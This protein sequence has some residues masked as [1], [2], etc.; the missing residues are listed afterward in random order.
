MSVY[1]SISRLFSFD[2]DGI[3][4][5][6]QY[7]TLPASATTLTLTFYAMSPTA[8]SCFI[9]AGFGARGQSPYI[10]RQ[11]ALSGAW[12]KYTVQAKTDGQTSGYVALVNQCTGGTNNKIYVDDISLQ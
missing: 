5:L 2:A 8:T 3:Y 6:D 4:E 12:T 9:V 7:V 10:E 11:I 1:L